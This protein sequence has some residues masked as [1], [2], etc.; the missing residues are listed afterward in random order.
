MRNYVTNFFE[1]SVFSLRPDETL[2][3]PVTIDCLAVD[4]GDYTVAEHGIKM[5]ARR[6]LSR[7]TNNRL[8]WSYPEAVP[9]HNS[10]TNPVIVGQVMSSLSPY[11][12]TFYS[13]GYNGLNINVGKQGATSTPFD[14]NEWLGIIVIEATDG[15]S[16]WNGN[17]YQAIRGPATVRGTSDLGAATTYPVDIVPASGVNSISSMNDESKGGFS[18]FY[19]SSTTAFNSGVSLAIYRSG[20]NSMHE[21]VDAILFEETPEIQ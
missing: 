7:H 20:R 14:T 19:G 21:S 12:S 10:Y 6:Q 15:G 1:L 17:G 3:G 8:Y 5:E 2:I 18:V 11:W 16:L 9:L 13:R 4:E